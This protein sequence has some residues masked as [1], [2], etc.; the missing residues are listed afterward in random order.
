M[1][2]QKP[3]SVSRPFVQPFFL[4]FWS[5][6]LDLIL[7]LPSAASHRSPPLGSHGVLCLPKRCCTQTVSHGLAV[8]MAMEAQVSCQIV[9]RAPA[10]KGI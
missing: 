5:G 2:L 3:L 4:G 6:S 7:S 8:T 1:F 10:E 9:E